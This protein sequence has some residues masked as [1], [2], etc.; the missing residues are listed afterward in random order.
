MADLRDV[1]EF[2]K[3][4][5]PVLGGL[6]ALATNS[7]EVDDAKRET[8]AKGVARLKKLIDEAG[9]ETDTSNNA[10]NEALV[11][12]H[13]VLTQ[14]LILSATHAIALDSRV[15]R[16]IE[17]QRTALKNARAL[18][19]LAEVFAPIVTL[20]GKA[21]VDEIARVYDGALEEIRN[22]QL[23]KDVLASTIE[24]VTTTGNLLLKLAI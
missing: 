5:L 10:G 8:L 11:R 17:Q 3:E 9:D 20:L 15:V 7:D 12:L 4:I 22:R 21:E 13:E 18:N 14:V 24:V 23:A 1:V 2:G 19:A 16:I 6:F